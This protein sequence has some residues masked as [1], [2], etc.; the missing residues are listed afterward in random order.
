MQKKLFLFLIISATLLLLSACQTGAEIAPEIEVVP[1]E[2]AVPTNTPPPTATPSPSPTPNAPTVLE[3]SAVAMENLTS[4]TQTQLN[5]ISST[6]ISNTQT[7]TCA[8]EQPSNA[9]CQIASQLIPPGSTRPLE[10]K[11]EILFLDGDAWTRQDGRPEWESVSQAD[12]EELSLIAQPNTPLHIPPTLLQEV[13]MTGVNE[14]DGQMM[15]EIEAVILETAVKDIL[16]TSMQGLLAFTENM[17]IDTTLWIGVDDFLIYQQT[18]LATF[19]FQGEPVEFKATI[20]N[21]EFNQP[22]IFPDPEA[23]N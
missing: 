14:L 4:V 16:G 13:Q 2:T 3:N 10:N 1:T 18:I 8:Y 23:T 20:N 6:L 9:Y 11:Y 17:E 19:T 15:Y 5:L 7:Q 22:Q 12:A 21:S